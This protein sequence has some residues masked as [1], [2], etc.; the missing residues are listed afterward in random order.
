MNPEATELLAGFV[1]VAEDPAL[2]TQ[3]R[4]DQA[5]V[6]LNLNPPDIQTVQSTLPLL[7]KEQLTPDQAM[8]LGRLKILLAE[9]LQEWTEAIQAM[10]ANH[11]SGQ[12]W[13]ASRCPVP[14]TWRTPVQKRRLP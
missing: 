10:P 11:C 6:A 9:N 5:E 7:E 1:A 3:A 4:L 13:K 8:Q 12:G 2:K 14:Q